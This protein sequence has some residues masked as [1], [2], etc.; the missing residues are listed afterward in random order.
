MLKGNSG[1]CLLCLRF[2]VLHTDIGTERIQT[3]TYVYA[4]KIRI[5][6][7]TDACLSCFEHAVPTLFLYI[8]I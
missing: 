5:A 3:K 2:T 1:I 4:Y 8:Y 7:T 6:S